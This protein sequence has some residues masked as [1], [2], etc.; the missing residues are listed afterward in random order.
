MLLKCALL[1][2]I[3]PKLDACAVQSLVI[4]LFGAASAAVSKRSRQDPMVHYI[5]P[6]WNMLSVIT[7][8]SRS[9]SIL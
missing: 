6:V 8:Q 1:R 2:T 7:R 9:N 3:T 4:R 5:C